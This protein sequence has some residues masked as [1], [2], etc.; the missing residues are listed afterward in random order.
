L[1]ETLEANVSRTK[2]LAAR[3]AVLAGAATLVVASAFADSRPSNETSWRGGN[4]GTERREGVRDRDERRRG[5]DSRNDRDVRGDGRRDDRR[6]DRNDGRYERRDDRSNNRQPYYARGRV[7]R[8]A[9]HGNGYRV[10]VGRERYPFFVPSSHYHRDRFRIGV[11]IN[12]G[13]YYNPAGYYD[14]YDGGRYAS[15]NG[16]RGVVERVDHRRDSFV[17]RDRST[18]RFVTVVSR[19]PLR[20]MRRGDIV[21]VD[22]EWTRPGVFRAWDVDLLDRY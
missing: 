9:P 6:D 12:L 14:Y 19:E 3:M 4:R 1:I 13:G 15:R 11:Q 7:S 8:V 18:G 10:W 17:L 22:G 16:L 20:R 2:E 21:E 5:D